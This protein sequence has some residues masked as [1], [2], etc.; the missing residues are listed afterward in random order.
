MQTS[1]TKTDLNL[2]SNEELLELAR[3]IDRSKYPIRAQFLLE[4]LEKRHLPD[5]CPVV[6]R[7]PRSDEPV[8]YLP[9][10]RLDALWQ[11]VQRLQ[12]KTE[13]GYSKGKM[14]TLLVLSIVLFGAL[15]I[16]SN[17]WLSALSIITAL[18][19]HEGGHVV[20]MKV[21]GY[22][23]VSVLF[24]PFFGAIASGESKE[25][26]PRENAIISISGPAIGLAV[27]SVSF[28]LF[29][30]TKAPIFAEFGFVSLVLNIFNL[31]PIGSLD[32]GRF[33]RDTVF[34]RSPHLEAGFS[35][36]GGCALIGLGVVWS[37][38]FLGAFGVAGLLAGQA[39]YS[40]KLAAAKT[41][42][43]EGKFLVDHLDR[44]TVSN[45]YSTLCEQSPDL[46]QSVETKNGTSGLAPIVIY[47]WRRAVGI[48][49]APASNSS[50]LIGI[51]ML[52]LV[53]IFLNVSLMPMP[54]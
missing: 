50:F 11:E 27:G 16:Q 53:L 31:L 4:A 39:T 46:V 29:D 32:G 26:M 22:S 5:P 7:A 48:S 54:K 25:F 34:L 42:V 44:E 21:L 41:K 30:I 10:D 24:L 14:L 17:D 37:D 28:L 2:L 36:L 40:W 23:N 51:G 15:D 6:E 45:I 33:L 43:A 9:V 1:K 52:L 38:I 19:V 35:L 49:N 12:F 47:I 8:V 3:T 20:A 13:S 18:L